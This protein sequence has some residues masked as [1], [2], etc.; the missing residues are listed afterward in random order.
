M[1]KRQGIL[2]VSQKDDEDLLPEKLARHASRRRAPEACERLQAISARIK[3][4]RDDRMDETLIERAQE[5]TR[6]RREQQELEVS[7]PYEVIVVR[8]IDELREKLNQDDG[9]RFVIVAISYGMATD[10]VGANTSSSGLNNRL[11]W[12]KECNPPLNGPRRIIGFS[13]QEPFL[14]QM[15][16]MGCDLTCSTAHLATRLQDCL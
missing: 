7:L 12:M 8:T 14:K 4:L 6:I 5:L 9:E 10:G 3:A 13:S 15:E 11:S 16:V 1:H 2:L